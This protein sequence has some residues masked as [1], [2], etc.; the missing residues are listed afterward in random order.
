MYEVVKAFE[1]QVGSDNPK[2]SKD[3]VEKIFMDELKRA[4][5]GNSMLEI[6]NWFDKYSIG[7]V[8]LYYDTLMQLYGKKFTT[9]VKRT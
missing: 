4:N 8:V 7:G 9:K 6:Q 2:A 5:M 1:R 3:D